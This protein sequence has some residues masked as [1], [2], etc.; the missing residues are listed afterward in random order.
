MTNPVMSNP[1][2]FLEDIK[3]KEKNIKSACAQLLASLRSINGINEGL[4]TKVQKSVEECLNTRIPSE[5]EVAAKKIVDAKKSLQELN[6][7]YHNLYHS[8][9]LEDNRETSNE[10]KQFCKERHCDDFRENMQWVSDI[11]GAIKLVYMLYKNG[12]LNKKDSTKA[13]E[14]NISRI[15]DV[16]D[17]NYEI[18]FLDISGNKK[19]RHIKRNNKTDF[20]NS[21]V[22]ETNQEGM[23][24]LSIKWSEWWKIPSSTEINFILETLNTKYS[25][26]VNMVNEQD[27]IALFMLLNN[28]YWQFFLKDKIFKCFDNFRWYRDY[29]NDSSRTGQILVIRKK[30]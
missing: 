5:Q 7:S 8:G 15:I 26:D 1:E 10:F 19:I 24:Y 22:G 9:S 16:N 14:Y 3:N 23:E 2:Q 11:S 30:S 13:W 4:I 18:G 25:K 17:L 29:D 28:C 20:I 12:K 27:R 21:S 6:R